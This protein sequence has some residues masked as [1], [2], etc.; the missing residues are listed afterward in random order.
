MIIPVL[1]AV[2]CSPGT[3]EAPP[4]ADPVGSPDPAEPPTSDTGTPLLPLAEYTWEPIAGLV[5]LW[6]PDFLASDDNLKLRRRVAAALRYDFEVLQRVVPEAGL[7]RVAGTRVAIN[8]ETPYLPW[9]GEPGRG[10][11]TH[12][13][14]SWLQANGLEP[15][16]E[17]VIELYNAEDYIIW[18]A[19]QPMVILHELTHVL[20][21]GADAQT[22]AS[23][24]AAFEQAERS[25]VYDSVPHILSAPS[26]RRR[27][28]AL[29]NVSEYGAELAEALFGRN[30][31]YPFVAS[32]LAVA[33]PMGCAAVARMWSTTCPR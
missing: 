2:S 5:V 3:A 9:R 7:Q 12:V 31:F 33:D 24:E 6:H 8:L 28:Y 18:R 19:E 11:A 30:D 25:G 27:A 16:R 20:M 32:D 10:A 21:L 22:H 15:E 13:S 29:T 17:G 1:L 4:R 23:L 26:A 14:A